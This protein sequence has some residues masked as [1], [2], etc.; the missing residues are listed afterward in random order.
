MKT[1]LTRIDDQE[2][3]L[4]VLQE[5]PTFLV[6][7]DATLIERDEG[8]LIVN[9][10]AGEILFR[11]IELL[12][13]RPPAEQE[14]EQE[15]AEAFGTEVASRFDAAL[16]WINPLVGK[17]PYGLWTGGCVP[18]GP[19]AW[20]TN[21]PAPPRSYLRGK[22]IFC[23]GVPNLMLRFVGKRVPTYGNDCYDGGMVA[24]WSYFDGFHQSF[25][26]QAV[27]RGDL[28]LRRYRN[29]EDQ[30]HVAVALGDGG[31]AHLLQSYWSHGDGLPGLNKLIS[32]STSHSV[33]HYERIVRVNNWIN[34]RGDEFYLLCRKAR[35]RVK[36]YRG[37]YA[38]EQLVNLA[39]T[40]N[41]VRG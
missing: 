29:V 31:D 13:K 2:V 32:V 41:R 30:G 18:S 1:V 9:P 39:V 35:A 5:L 17:M 37:V 28:I 27:R 19:P 11:H 4:E 10:D 20:A 15:F 34:Y 23:A 38:P 26:L 25:D 7:A 22:R 6:C 16:E 21:A 12:P 40:R 36:P 33:V 24:Y 3:E 8:T 14:S